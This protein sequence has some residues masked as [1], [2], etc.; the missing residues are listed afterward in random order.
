MRW[1]E[2]GLPGNNQDDPTTVVTA[3]V[4]EREEP[5]IMRL[6]LSAEEVERLEVSPG[7]WYFPG[8]P[9]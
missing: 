4:E 2:A 5:S 7:Q 1:W 9:P 8:T 6:L 3:V